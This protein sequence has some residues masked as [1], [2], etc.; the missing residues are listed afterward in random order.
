MEIK[1]TDNSK[2]GMFYIDK[3]GEILAELSYRWAGTDSIY[4]EHTEVGNAL[5]GKGIGKQL[6][7][8]AVD[9]AREKGIKIVP[10]CSFARSVFG[11]VPEFK[12][13]L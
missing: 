6:V 3:E 11:K 1:Q 4:I 8:K 9:F 12:D 5:K 2:N 7:S 13:V 10:L